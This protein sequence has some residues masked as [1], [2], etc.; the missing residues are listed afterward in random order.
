MPNNSHQTLPEGTTLNGGQYT[1]HETLGQGPLAITYRA[2]DKDGCVVAI[3]ELFLRADCERLAGSARVILTDP[4]KQGRMVAYKKEFSER[5]RIL[6]TIAHARV[7]KVTDV[8]EDNDTVYYVREYSVH[9]SLSRANG[10]VAMPAELVLR[11]GE[12]VAE[13]LKVLHDKRIAHY[14]V[15]P[16]NILMTADG[17]VKISDFGFTRNYDE[18]GRDAATKPITVAPGFAPL[19]QYSSLRDFSPRVDVYALGATLYTML[20]GDAPAEARL[21]RPMPARPSGISD[22]TW[23]LLTAALALKA[24]DRPTMGDLLRQI[25]LADEV[26]EGTAIVHPLPE[27]DAPKAKGTRKV[28]TTLAIILLLLVV[29]IG[30]TWFYQESAAPVDD[31]EKARTESPD[32][33]A[34]PADSTAGVAAPSVVHYKNGD[35]F[36]GQVVDDQPVA[37]TLYHKNGSYFRGYFQDGQPWNGQWFDENHD[38]IGIIKDGK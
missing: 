33:D 34:A 30:A 3:K 2:T 19:E 14:A 20:T 35:I 5:A 6:Q 15:M 17:H 28:M 12:E 31:G 27:D 7:A 13:G 16:Q 8:F 23:A 22:G 4:N 10:P 1:L 38:V 21:G 11:F 24:D 37:G 36:R 18:N 9:G 29:V 32:G 26:V 25:R